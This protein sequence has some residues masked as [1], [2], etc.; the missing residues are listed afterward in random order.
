MLWNTNIRKVLYCIV[1]AKH[2]FKA[3]GQH[4]ERIYRLRNYYEP[5]LAVAALSGMGVSL[6]DQPDFGP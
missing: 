5:Q 4:L 1:Y 2:I 6:R 3:P